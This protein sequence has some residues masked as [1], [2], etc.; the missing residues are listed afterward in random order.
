MTNQIITLR[1]AVTDQITEYVG[2]AAIY[3]HHR[4]YHKLHINRDG[5]L[6]WFEA[7][8]KA[9]DLIDRKA[10]HFCAV[11]SLITVGTGSCKCNCDWCDNDEYDTQDDAI[12]D[13]FADSD[14]TWIEENMIYRLNQLPIGYFDDEEG[15]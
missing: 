3:S 13:A 15:E 1:Q 7:I 6:S 2:Q 14:I 10:D 9:D 4:N 5:S 11:Q 12:A 8:N